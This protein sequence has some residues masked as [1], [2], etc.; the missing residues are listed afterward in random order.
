MG[1]DGLLVSGLAVCHSLRV[2]ALP[3]RCQRT[4]TSQRL[5]HEIRSLRRGLLRSELLRGLELGKQRR[6]LEAAPWQV[7]VLVQ[8]S[9]QE[10]PEFGQVALQRAGHGLGL[11]VPGGD[12]LLSRLTLLLPGFLSRIR[13]RRLGVLLCPRQL[14]PGLQP[15]VLRLGLLP[16]A[17]GADDEPGH[18]IRLLALSSGHDTTPRS[19]IDDLPDTFCDYREYSKTSCSAF[20]IKRTHPATVVTC[21]YAW[22][23]GHT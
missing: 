22:H 8:G 15:L 4:K 12:L 11:H 19:S 23:Q 9:H 20:L 14:S 18:S 6:L 10:R 16:V 17:H 21:R 3:A 1:G 7:W 5:W 2:C 13:R